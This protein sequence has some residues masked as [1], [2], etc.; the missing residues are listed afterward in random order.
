MIWLR[1]KRL[2]II[3][4]RKLWR[5]ISVRFSIPI[6][7]SSGINVSTIN[8]NLI[9]RMP[10]SKSLNRPI[11]YCLNKIKLSKTLFFIKLRRL[12]SI[13]K[14][15][16]RLTNSWL[17]LKII[18]NKLKII[19]NKVKIHKINS[20]ILVFKSTKKEKKQ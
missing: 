9:I 5:I 14:N 8:N 10:I 12:S 3:L 20:S 13:R 4:I 6:S 19:R 17:L 2:I 7:L 1:R 15:S 16:E 11:W 18:R